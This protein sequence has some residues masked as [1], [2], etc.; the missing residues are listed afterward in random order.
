MTS[1][2]GLTIRRKCN[3]KPL[4]IDSR[5]ELPVLEQ[6]P[7]GGTIPSKKSVRSAAPVLPTGWANLISNHTSIFFFFVLV[8]ITVFTESYMCIRCNALSF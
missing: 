1:G 7:R 6:D 8:S 3:E 5:Q 4:K 2:D